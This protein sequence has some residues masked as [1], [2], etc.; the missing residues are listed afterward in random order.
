M[1]IYQGKPIWVFDPQLYETAMHIQAADCRRWLRRQSHKDIDMTGKG[2][3]RPK[4]G[5][6]GMSF[7]GTLWWIICY[8]AFV[9]QQLPSQ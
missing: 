7:W 6:L 3:Q 4:A 1:S 8:G 5:H 9:Q 2:N